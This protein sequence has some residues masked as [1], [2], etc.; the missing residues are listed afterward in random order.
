[1]CSI[2]TLEKLDAAH[3]LLH[4]GA[5]PVFIHAQVKAEDLP[6]VLP[7]RDGNAIKLR[8]MQT[9]AQSS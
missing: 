5:G 8:F 2:C 9:L 3:A 7:N 4:S 1:V 6:R